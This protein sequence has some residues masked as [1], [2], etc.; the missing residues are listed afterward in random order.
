MVDWSIISQYSISFYITVYY[1]ISLILCG[2]IF[3]S[4][5]Q[6]NSI[7]S[8]TTLNFAHPSYLHIGRKLYCSTELSI[9]L[10]FHFWYDTI[11]CICTICV[12]F[13]P[14]QIRSTRIWHRRGHCK[15]WQIVEKCRHGT[16]VSQNVFCNFSLESKY[17]SL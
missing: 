5:S 17:F 1:I 9:L 16:C 10:S 8:N 14:Y 11:L 15:R 13:C 3:Y 12:R 4:T 2:I 7:P 6:F